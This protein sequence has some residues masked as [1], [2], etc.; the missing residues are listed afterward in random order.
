MF[1]K[2]KTPFCLIPVVFMCSCS[3]GKQR[4][5]LIVHNAVIY[6]VDEAFSTMESMAIN[7]GLIV[8]TG[9][10]DDLF[11]RYAAKETIDLQGAFVYPGFIDPHCHFFGYGSAFLSADLS[12]STS[13]EEM[14]GRL[15]KHHQE[16]QSEWLTGR[17]W[18]QNIWPGQA[19]PNRYDLDKAF[20]DVPVLL[21]RID[22]HAA[23]ASSEAL[24][25]AQ[26]SS[27]TRVAGGQVIL[28]NGEPGGML[29]DNA[30]NLVRD[31]IPSP[32]REEEEQALI[33]AQKE[34]FAV[35]LTSVGDAGL[36]KDIIH[37]IDSMQKAGDLQMRVYAMLNPTQENY[38]AFLYNGI[39][40]TSHL[41]V[42]SVKLFADGALGS[43]GA[44]LLEPYND[45][46]TAAGLL[47]ETPEHMT[48]V[49]EKAY[50]YGYQVNTHCIGDSAVRLMLDIYGTLLPENND[51]RWRI[52]HAQTVHPDD[53]HRFGKYGII[54]SVQ[55]TH[56]TSDMLWAIDRLGEERLK[57]A[58]AYKQLLEQNGWLANGSDFPIEPINP[59]FGFYTAVARKD[60][61][62][63]PAEGFQTENALSREQALRAMT[64]W[65][66]RAQ[67]EENSKGSLEA[68]KMADFVVLPKDLMSIPED[69]IPRLQVINTYLDGKLVFSA[70]KK[71]L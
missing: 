68:G 6:T 71:N 39:Y 41:S 19:F 33:N 67:F 53:M 52:E 70:N 45:D 47:V 60:L 35:G 38:E 59:L 40:Q 20:G 8:A 55:T 14:I 1:M 26:I 51:L 34:L 43:R 36:D 21:T 25:R 62:G 65:A 42:R 3:P 57:T 46:P 27:E 37:L 49:A 4:V 64:I 9:K 5:D 54:P 17:G 12:G 32:G 31:L 22:G 29:I 2:L 63:L 13:L 69:H 56:A 44:K 66:A 61:Q 15:K 50:Q 28:L 23:V 11:A 48:R 7:D 10:A 18:D 58:Y 16:H 24:R 30:I